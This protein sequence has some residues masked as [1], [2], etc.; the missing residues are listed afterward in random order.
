[1]RPHDG[2][3]VSRDQRLSYV[4]RVGGTGDGHVTAGGSGAHA[5]NGKVVAMGGPMLTVSV[6]DEAARIALGVLPGDVRVLVWDGVGE[7]P[8]HGHEIE[9]FAGRFNTRPSRE[10]LESLPRL[11]AVQLVSAGVEPWLSVVP[12]GVVLC[13]GRGVHGGSTAELAVGG[14]IAMLRGIVPFA[15]AQR[16]HRWEHGFTEGLDGRRV[17]VIGAG[18]IGTRIATAV[19]VFGADVTLVARRARPGVSGIAELKQLL[20]SQDVVALA[21]PHTEDTHHLVDAEFLAALHDDALLVN[22]SRGG[23]VDT[24]ALVAEV[25]CRR[26][27]AFLDVTDPEPLPV[28]HPLWDAPNVLITPHVGTIRGWEER[29]YRL[30]REQILRLRE[31]REL[32]NQVG[33]HY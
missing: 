33:E 14:M 19:R 10:T 15:M 5:R 31:G 2:G 22:V 24:E 13:N 16:A 17:A 27:R 7:I 26:I 28:G 3:I 21:V 30:V 8:V 9:F 6:P 25:L 11:R 1:M 29:A 32:V 4:Q 20:P 12:D 23:V 18:D